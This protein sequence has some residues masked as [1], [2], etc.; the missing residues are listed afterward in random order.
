LAFIDLPDYDLS[1]FYGLIEKIFQNEEKST[2][3]TGFDIVGHIA[4]RH[5][6]GQPFPIYWRLLV[7]A[8]LA[9]I[10]I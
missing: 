3:K 6:S 9:T 10:I 4:S 8:E 7:K 2:F 1:H 5:C